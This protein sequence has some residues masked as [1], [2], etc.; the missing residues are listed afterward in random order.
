MPK[1]KIKPS[2]KANL[3]LFWIGKIRATKAASF[4][5]CTFFPVTSRVQSV[6]KGSILNTSLEARALSFLEYVQRVASQHFG[7]SRLKL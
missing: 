6:S 2:F 3:I 1:A 7:D 5:P 4:F